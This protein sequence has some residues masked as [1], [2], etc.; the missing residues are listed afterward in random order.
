MGLDSRYYD[1][2]NKRGNIIDYEIEFLS[3]SNDLG[4]NPYLTF[5]ISAAFELTAII[6]THQILD[7]LGRKRP[8]GIFLFMAGVSCV[9]II[10]IGE[11]IFEENM[12]T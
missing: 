12:I 9:S 6:I 10:F 11:N 1:K 5:I 4:V 8:Y 7:R 3:Q 2:I